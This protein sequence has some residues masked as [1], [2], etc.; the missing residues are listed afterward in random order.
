MR[1]SVTVRTSA[2][3]NKLVIGGPQPHSFPKIKI[4]R[5][6]SLAELNQK[7][8]SERALVRLQ[9][10]GGEGPR[11]DLGVSRTN[12]LPSAQREDASTLQ[13]I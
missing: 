3:P 6:L 11:M 5:Q 2:W 12:R 9:G 7:I 10:Q 13:A 1:S 4:C 8:E